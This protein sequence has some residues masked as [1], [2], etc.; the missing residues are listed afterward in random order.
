[1]IIK[2]LNNLNKNKW[3]R[4]LMINMLMVILVLIIA[5]ALWILSLKYSNLIGKFANKIINK[6]KN[7]FN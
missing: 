5:I 6:I 1:M 3:M 2:S 7:I 4:G